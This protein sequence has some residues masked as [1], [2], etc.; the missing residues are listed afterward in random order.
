MEKIN[1]VD[2]SQ[3]VEESAEKLVAEKRNKAASLVKQELQRI[4]QLKID[5]KKIDKDR[6]N[7]QDKLDKAQ[8]K[9][10]KIKNGDWSVLAEPKENQGN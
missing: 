5:I 1:N 3:L 8:A 7:K 10:D 2:L 6:K 4:E 9:M